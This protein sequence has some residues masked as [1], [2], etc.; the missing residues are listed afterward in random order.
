M[1]QTESE[2]PSTST[3]TDD[4]QPKRENTCHVLL[5]RMGPQTTSELGTRPRVD[6][7]RLYDIWKFNPDTRTEA[8]WYVKGVHTP[9]HALRHWLAVNRETLEANDVTQMSLANKLGGEF[10]P[11][12]KQLISDDKYHWLCTDTT[13]RTRTEQSEI[14]CPRCGDHVKNF[15]NHIRSCDGTSSDD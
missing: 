11:L 9:E 15:P 4:Q 8:V 3:D 12:F 7:R 14:P 10:K 1:S 13:E 2:S 5:T 6:A